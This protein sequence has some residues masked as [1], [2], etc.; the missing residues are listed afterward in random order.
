VWCKGNPYT[1]L[2]FDKKRPRALKKK[3]YKK[4]VCDRL[5]IDTGVQQLYKQH[6][7]KQQLYKQHNTNNDTPVQTQHTH[8]QQ[9]PCEII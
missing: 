8:T 1:L 5:N 2:L 3:L 9:H 7:H 4:E 6:K